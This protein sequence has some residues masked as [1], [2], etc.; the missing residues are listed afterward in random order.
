MQLIV[1]AYPRNLMKADEY[2]LSQAAQEAPEEPGNKDEEPEDSDKKKGNTYKA[3]A[4][5]LGD[6][7]PDHCLLVQFWQ[8]LQADNDVLMSSV[9]TRARIHVGLE[10]LRET[11]PVYTNTDVSIVNRKN[12][13]GVWRS[14]VWTRRDFE[15]YQIMLAPYSSAIKETAILAPMHANVNLPK[16]GRG[17]HP[18]NKS[19]A[20]DGRSR[21]M[22][23]PAGMVMQEQLTGS[24]FWA[25]ARSSEKKDANLEF[26]MVPWEFQTKVCLPGPGPAKK[27]KTQAHEWSEYELPQFPMIVNK[28]AV[29]KNTQLVV[30]QAGIKK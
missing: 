30:F 23:A 26:E 16:H 5:C 6:S 21:N 12:D 13:K 3:P 20:L 24:L 9:A 14:E 29:P 2:L 28:K 25:L 8:K 18:E 27:R 10:A 15:A 17:A 22:I 4:W 19:L 11:L 7:D 1:P